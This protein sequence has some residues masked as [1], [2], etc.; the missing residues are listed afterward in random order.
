M[1][2]GEDHTHVQHESSSGGQAGIMKLMTTLTIHN[3]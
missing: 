1:M 3:I 2:K